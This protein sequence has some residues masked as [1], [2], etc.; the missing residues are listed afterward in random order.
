MPSGNC[1]VG[2]TSAR[3]HRARALRLPSTKPSPSTGTGTSHALRRSTSRE[4][5]RPGSSTHA[6]TALLRSRRTMRPTSASVS[7]IPL[8]DHQPGPARASLLEAHG[9][10]PQGLAATPVV[11]PIAV[12]MPKPDADA[13]PGRACDP[14]PARKQVGRLPGRVEGAARRAPDW[15]AFQL[16]ARH[17]A[18]ATLPARQ[19]QLRDIVTRPAAGF[20]ESLR[21]QLAERIER[22]GARDV[23]LAR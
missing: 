2:V 16:R 4:V 11:Q 17:R 20:E 22:H 13:S 6:L 19:P 15:T 21:G 23:E 10:G 5:P 9:D 1:R 14:R 18:T 12:R 7:A 8:S 3:R